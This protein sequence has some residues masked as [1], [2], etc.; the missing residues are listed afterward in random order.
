MNDDY[1][2]D[3]IGGFICCYLVLVTLWAFLWVVYP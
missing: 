2:W 3:A 1:D